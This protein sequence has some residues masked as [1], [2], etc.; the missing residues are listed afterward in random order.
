M[1]IEW[2]HQIS[3]LLDLLQDYPAVA[4]LGARQVGKTTLS[5]QL[6][7][8]LPGPVT[9]FDLEDPRHLERLSDPMLELEPFEGLIILDEIQL[10]PEL[11]PVLR[12]LADRRPL[13][14]RFL[15]LGSASPNLLRQSSESLAGRI[16]YHQLDGLSLDEVGIDHLST[17]WQRGGFPASYVARSDAASFRWR[18]DFIQTFVARDLPQL[19]IQIP[20][21]TLWRFWSMIAHYHGQI[22]NGAEL[23]RA[24]GVSEATVK[25]YRDLLTSALVLRQLQLWYENISKRQVRAPK[26]YL[27][28]SGLLHSLLDVATMA[29]LEN[30]P[31]V[32]ASWEGFALQQVT[33]RLGAEPEQCFFWAT[34]AGA[35]LDLLVVHGRRRL[36]FEFKRTS[37][38][39][40][41]KSMHVAMADL[42]LDRLHVIYPGEETFVMGE[43][44]QAVGLS[45]LLV[46]VEP[47]D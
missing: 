30:H 39:R 23:A 47:L 37:T 21:V 34:H 31:K 16:H 14:A 28:D 7:P 25:R 43:N 45:R 4:I 15:V 9:V 35:E 26:V 5:R 17:L 33:A 22:W 24:F 2:Y 36:G 1:L 12:V 41:R 8:H 6:V 10:R 13:S 40:R 11:F 38:P 46:D 19:G 18:R 32:G 42:G 27:V 3:Q 44:I 20:S 29:D